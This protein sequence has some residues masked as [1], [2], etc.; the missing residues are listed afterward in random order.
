MTPTP[1]PISRCNRIDGWVVSPSTVESASVDSD[2]LASPSRLDH[3]PRFSSPRFLGIVPQGQQDDVCCWY[4]AGIMMMIK[5]A[6]QY[7]ADAADKHAAASPH[8]RTCMFVLSV[9]ISRRVP[10]RPPDSEYWS[11]LRLGNQ[12]KA[13]NLSRLT[14][15]QA[16]PS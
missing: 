14:P 12:P 2:S 5:T 7:F 15:W 16:R 6:R 11:M 3:R 13:R 8:H 10:G 9:L 1:P 4:C